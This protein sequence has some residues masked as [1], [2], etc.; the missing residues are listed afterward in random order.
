[1]YFSDLGVIALVLALGFSIY[2][3]LAAVLGAL[4]QLPRL[5]ASAKRG[6]LVVAFFM[7][8]ASAALV[9]SEERRVG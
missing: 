1:M 5:V 8:L 3:L 2:T 9:R 6:V 7:L 4:R